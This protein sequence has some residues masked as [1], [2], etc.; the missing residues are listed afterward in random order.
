MRIKL[1]INGKSVT[2]KSVET[3]IGKQRL[4]QI[5]KEA[6]E[7]FLEDQNIANDFFIGH[8]RM[9]SIIFQF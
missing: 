8:G 3:L 2:R 5:I 9:L 6:K 4:E 1:F 7:T